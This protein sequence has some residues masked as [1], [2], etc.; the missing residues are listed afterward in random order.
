MERKARILVYDIE[1]SPI[2]GYTWGFWQTDVVEILH[3]WQILSVAWKWLG[4][5]KVHVIGQDDFKGYVPGVNNDK[6]VVKVLRDLLDE[7]DIVVAH[8]GNRFDQKK[9]KTRIIMHGLTPPSPFKQVDTKIVAKQNFA[10]TRN[11]LKYLARDLET[12]N[13]K[14]GPGG[15]STWQGCL[16]GD[17]KAWKAMKKYNKG[18]ITSLEDLY[19]RFLPWISNHPN[20]ARLQNRPTACPKCGKGPMQRRGERTTNVGKYFRYQCQS[21]E[22]WSCGRLAQADELKPEY[23]NYS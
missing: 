4:D 11:N 15:F 12:R 21:C 14:G 17:K 1:T 6:E 13:Q 23:V 10:F 20:M 19:L 9:V 22:G 18:D 5:K 8:N 16:A 2:I 3:D 7:A